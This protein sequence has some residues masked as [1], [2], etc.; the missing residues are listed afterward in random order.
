MTKSNGLALVSGFIKL[1]I[2][3]SLIQPMLGCTQATENL[4]KA[5]LNQEIQA[6]EN[7]VKAD[8]NQEIQLHIDQMALME[9]K[10]MQVKVL[11]I[12]EDSRC[13]VDAV[14][15]QPGQV[16]IAFE[17]VKENSK[18]EEVELTLRAAQENL[19]V[20]NFDGYSMTLKNVEPLPMTNQEKIIQSD[21]IVTIVVSKS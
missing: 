9:S 5:D 10:T 11:D 20:K 21:Y 3:C 7:L 4:S 15:V 13:P 6:T 2:I 16:T 1:I 8:L 17:V 12:V 19:A 14:C 18:P